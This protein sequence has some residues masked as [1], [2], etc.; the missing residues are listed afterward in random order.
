MSV[1]FTAI[2]GEHVITAKFVTPSL[3]PKLKLQSLLITFA[4]KKKFYCIEKQDPNAPEEEQ[5]TT[6][7]SIPGVDAETVNA[8]ESKIVQYTPVP[9]QHAVKAI[10]TFRANKNTDFI[11]EKNTA[12]AELEK[13]KKALPQRHSKKCLSQELRHQC[14]ML[15]CFCRHR[16]I[17]VWP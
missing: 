10:D 16:I 5:V 15:E 2:L 7:T 6:E 14:S 11:T 3:V 13:K 1:P 12:K 9:V 8:I 17:C 4:P